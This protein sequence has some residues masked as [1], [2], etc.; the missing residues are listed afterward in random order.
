[1]QSSDFRTAGSALRSRTPTGLVV[2]AWLRYYPCRK[3][4]PLHVSYDGP[5]PI[6]PSKYARVPHPWPET[7]RERAERYMAMLESGEAANRTELARLEGISKPMV[8]KIL[9][10]LDGDV[11]TLAA[12]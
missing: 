9:K 5:P 3:G 1:M 4:E 7:R 8:T 2:E 12:P 6:V 11:G 10:T